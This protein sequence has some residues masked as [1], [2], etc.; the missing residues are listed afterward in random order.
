MFS[1]LLLATL[2]SFVLAHFSM[3][4]FAFAIIL[5]VTQSW[6][7]K[8]F[9]SLI[10]LKSASV[11]GKYPDFTEN[12]TRSDCGTQPPGNLGRRAHLKA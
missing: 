4:F 9:F 7:N 10:Q 11:G 8:L 2:I 12:G 6:F 3:R 1:F 5:Q